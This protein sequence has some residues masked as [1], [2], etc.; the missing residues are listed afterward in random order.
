MI[1]AKHLSFAIFNRNTNH[2]QVLNQAINF[3]ALVNRLDQSF[4][5]IAT[6]RYF[7]K[8]RHI[9]NLMQQYEIGSDQVDLVFNDWLSR[10]C[11]DFIRS[12]S[13]YLLALDASLAP[14]TNFEH[15]VLELLGEIPESLETISI[16]PAHSSAE[17]LLSGTTE[18]LKA[19]AGINKMGFALTRQGAQKF[20]KTFDQSPT[21]DFSELIRLS[22]MAC[23]SILPNST[24]QPVYYL[25]ILNS[26]NAYETQLTAE[27]VV[28]TEIVERDTEG[29]EKI[30]A[31]VQAFIS[32]WYSTWHNIYQVENACRDFGFDT[33]VLNTTIHD[34]PGWTNSIPIS[35]F[36][37]FEY[38]CKN[39]DLKND[40]LFFI[41][42]DV[43][44]DRW[45]DFFTYAD[46]VLGLDDVGTFSP[47]LTFQ[48]YQLNR[49]PSLKFE[50][51]SAIAIIFHNDILSTFIHKKVILELQ[52][53][54]D[55]FNSREDTFAP[56]IG[57]GLDTIIR[58]ITHKLNLFNLRDRSNTVL[59][60]F[61]RS[62]DSSQ[63]GQEGERILQFANDY[64]KLANFP[65]SVPIDER[66][67]DWQTQESFGR[68]V[69]YLTRLN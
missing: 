66:I 8:S 64:F 24:N 9:R 21:G 2:D 39:F 3:G 7:K 6:P 1:Q 32:H 58:E 20:I 15:W 65:E 56:S 31:K 41:T 27:R 5:Y 43:K 63:A 69:Q 40:Y 29:S 49:F 12:D 18:P 42:A 22:N 67:K 68:L 30:P 54:F 26:Q 59:H 47:T 28:P 48:E 52:L 25:D 38:A 53:F 36:R 16:C 19:S 17:E 51:E 13:D 4:T 50:S 11:I 34:K 35:F 62:Y 10:T 57:H 55:Y 60:P 37:Q 33:T 14:G 46:D 45:Q 23:A 61:S 44:L